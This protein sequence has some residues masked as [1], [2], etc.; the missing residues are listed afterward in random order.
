MGASDRISN[1]AEDAKGKAKEGIGE[2]TD[3]DNLKNE[4]KVDQAKGQAKNVAEDA[5]DKASEAV[6]NVTDKV[7][8]NND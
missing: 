4:G 8:G 1:A 3:N 5:K 7:S 2:A 6:K